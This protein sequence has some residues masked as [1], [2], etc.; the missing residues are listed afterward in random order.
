MENTQNESYSKSTEV[1]GVTETTK[2]NEKDLIVIG[3]S[4]LNTKKATMKW[5]DRAIREEAGEDIIDH[6][7]R[8][9][10][11]E[12]EAYDKIIKLRVGVNY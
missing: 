9:Y 1:V 6:F 3:A 2:L 12:C 4:L 7:K 8:R 11:E 10:A 5:L